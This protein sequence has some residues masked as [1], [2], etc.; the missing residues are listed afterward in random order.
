ML[1]SAGL[2]AE[3][4]VRLPAAIMGVVRGSLGISHLAAELR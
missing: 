1:S 3:Y 2:R 4:G